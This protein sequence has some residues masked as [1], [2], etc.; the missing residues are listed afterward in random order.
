MQLALTAML[1][2][3]APPEAGKACPPGLT[4]KVQPELTERMNGRVAVAEA[5]SVTRI[6]KLKAPLLVGMPLIT[7]A[8]LS[9]RPGGKVPD[10]NDQL[11]GCV[12][13]VAFSVC[14]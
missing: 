14:K 2:V 8:A 9:V 11:Y 10:A 13:P 7:P 1:I 4:A 3:P 6:V 5:A 12:P